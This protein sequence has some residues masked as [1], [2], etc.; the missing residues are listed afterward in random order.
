MKKK[1]LVVDDDAAVRRFMRRALQR[2]EYEVIEAADGDEAVELTAEKRPDLVLLDMH[3]PGLGGIAA[4]SGILDVDPGMP[5]IMVTGD[6]DM[7]RAKL[8]VERG[9]RGH[10]TKPFDLQSLR[11]SVMD[12]LPV[13]S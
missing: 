4:L 2:A 1:L 3:M 11:T 12:N 6:G 13:G 8:A 10:M 7:E 9:A 5:V